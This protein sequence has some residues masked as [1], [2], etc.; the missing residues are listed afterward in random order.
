MENPTPEIPP[1][2]KALVYESKDTGITLNTVPTPK[3]HPGAVLCKVLASYISAG[4]GERLGPSA[5]PVFLTH[6]I[7]MIPGVYSIG[8]VVAIGPDT[9]KLT[10]GQ[11]VL[12]DPFVRGRDDSDVQI[13]LAAFDGP[14]PA[15]KKLAAEYWRNGTYAEYVR[16]PLE[17]TWALDEARLC[18]SPSDG[19]LGYTIPELIAIPIFTCCYGGLRGIDLKAGETII[20]SPATG[21][22]SMSAVAIANAIGA[23]VTAVSRNAER[24]KKLQEMFPLIR[25][26]IPTGDVAKDTEAIVAGGGLADV[27]MDVSPPAATGST[28]IES[29]IGALK[30]Y[31]RI[32]LMGGRMDPKLPIGFFQLMFKNLTVRGQYAYE[33]EDVKGLIKLVESGRLPIGKKA[34]LPTVAEVSLE[35]FKDALAAAARDPGLTGFVTFVP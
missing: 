3:V 25:T 15:S 33:R 23:N 22:F 28:Y 1:T 24:L 4:I 18:G 8:R 2:M 14:T 27:V 10:V 12:I 26:V 5:G 7:P 17:N 21:H 9:T 34:G 29:C 16:S 13:L 35:Q 19:G 11:L 31:G 20:I 32:S 30:Q 6:P